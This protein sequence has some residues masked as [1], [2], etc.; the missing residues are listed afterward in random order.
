MMYLVHPFAYLHFAFS[1]I[2]SELIMA[3]VGATGGAVTVALGLNS[4]AKVS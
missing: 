4:L 2:C 3:Y 1:T